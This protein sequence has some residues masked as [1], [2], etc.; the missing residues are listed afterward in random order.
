[1]LN[2][3]LFFLCIIAFLYV[4]L[5]GCILSKLLLIGVSVVF[6]IILMVGIFAYGFVLGYFVINSLTYL[7]IELIKIKRLNSTY[8]NFIFF[9]FYMF[10]IG[11]WMFIIHSQFKIE[12]L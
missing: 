2:K 12:V 8:D 5:V 4:I 10:F 3:I 11:S 9:I 1:M 7:I 6:L